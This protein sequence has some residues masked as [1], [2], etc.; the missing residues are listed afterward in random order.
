MGKLGENRLLIITE[1]MTLPVRISLHMFIFHMS[2]MDIEYRNIIFQ[3]T[4]SFHFVITD[5]V[6]YMFVIYI[7]IHYFKQIISIINTN[8]SNKGA[9]IF[10]YEDL[11]L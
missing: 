2:Y 1:N 10:E 7:H 5:V 3:D 8:G 11:L 4:N 6:V 9:I